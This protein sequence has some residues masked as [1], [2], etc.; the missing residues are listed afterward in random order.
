[1]P[2]RSFHRM[3]R[4]K[5]D[6]RLLEHQRVLGEAWIEH[7][8]LDDQRFL[9][10]DRVAAEGQLA[11]G[12]LDRQTLL[13]LEPLAVAFHEGDP[14]EWHVEH[15]LRHAADLV[16]SFFR[17]R[18]DRDTETELDESLRLVLGNEGTHHFFRL[19][20]EAAAPHH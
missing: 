16:E 19:R 6:A 9:A 18:I 13:R 7:R 5:P 15:A 14:R 12:V 10:I 17:L 11:R 20:P 8:V 1:M 2:A 4:V 3:T